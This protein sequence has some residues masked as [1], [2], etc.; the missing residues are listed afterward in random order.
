MDTA[1][2]LLAK[3]EFFRAKSDHTA[4]VTIWRSM[5][6]QAPEDWRL[7]LELKRDLKAGLHYPD[8]DHF[9]RRAA[10]H[11]PDSEWLDHYASL[12]AFHGSDLDAV[13]SRAR[14][15][16]ESQPDSARLHAILGDVARQRRDWNEALLRF[17]HALRL[18]PR[19]KG[20][21]ARHAVAR[22]YAALA[23]APWPHGGGTYRARVLNLDRNPERLDEIGRQL[24]GQVPRWER[25]PAIEGG[26][27]PAA[28]MRRLTGDAAAP[29]GTLG[30]FLGHAAAWEALLA[31]A[32]AAALVLE[33]DVI[34][35][36][37][38]PPDLAGFGL[39]E[40]WD[41]CFVNDRLDPAAAAHAPGGWREG[42]AR[43]V[44]LIEAL[45]AAFLP[46]DNAPGGDG[47]LISRAGA[48]ALVD[49]VA[50]DGFAGDVDWRLLA[51]ALGPEER[52]RI[53][54][55]F[56]ARRE[57]DRLAAALPSRPPL[58]ALVHTPALIRTV[59]ISSDREDQ[60]RL[61]PG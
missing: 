18:D 11:L 7:A 34:P 44:P 3:A 60:N 36:L 4:A 14:V 13:D 9:F 32:D 37:G 45:L 27:L 51:Y 5:L 56:H 21:A 38:L 55:H 33:D 29:R 46:D 40:G 8:S 48:R 22:R 30:C 35:L 53:P 57:L 17:G 61:H 47:Y 31:S 1:N 20:L 39:P 12:Y 19:D 42:P 54:A 41:L 43:C 2:D 16:L 50:A 58:R 26:R 25:Q 6:A 28:A 52:A 24:H 59:G 49:R 15:M 23:A 10:R